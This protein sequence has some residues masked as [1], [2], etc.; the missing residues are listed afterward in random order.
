MIATFA[1][2]SRT[3]ID[4]QFVW[5]SSTTFWNLSAVTVQL[6]TGKCLKRKG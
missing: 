2:K 5:Y 3:K 6:K 4:V 1:F